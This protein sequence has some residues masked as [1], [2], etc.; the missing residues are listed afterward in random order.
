MIDSQVVSLKRS[1]N[2]SKMLRGVVRDRYLYL[3]SAVGVVWA[4][5]FCYI[6]IYGIIVAFKRY[7]VV[8]GIWNSP[9]IGLENFT[10]FF[11]N[12]FAFRLIRNTFLLGSLS[13][14][15]GF[16]PPIILALLLNELR[17]GL[18][19]RSVQTISYL[20]HFIAIV[21]IVGMLKDFFGYDGL[22]NQITKMFGAEN[23][24]FFSESSWFRTLYI[25][26]G[27]WQGVGY[28]SIIYLATLSGI[29]PELY[30]CA[31]VE[32]ANRFQLV[33]HITLPC[34]LPT[35]MILF[36]LSTAGIV[37]VGFEKVYLMYSPVIYETADVIATY[38]YR[39][40]M[41]KGQIGYGAAVGL[42]NQLVNFIFLFGANAL[43]RKY[44]EYS[45][46]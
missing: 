21:I 12:P 20:P 45:M 15:I 14:V 33:T 30:E 16:S 35:I 18:F 28:S 42:F 26:S 17:S 11:K 7:D 8:E 36:I 4:F 38:T 31:T 46:W 25:G 2:T 40:A 43:S 6:P 24:N 39:V 19:K 27:I 5:I 9:W 3:M 23:I 44:T 37:S 10:N 32:G 1:S 13:L 41:E 34:M 22:V 29:N